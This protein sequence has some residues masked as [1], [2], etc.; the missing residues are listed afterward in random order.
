MTL[1]RPRNAA[2]F[3]AK[4]LPAEREFRQSEVGILVVKSAT[5]G[6]SFLRLKLS[7]SMRGLKLEKSFS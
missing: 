3:K 2:R 7:F 5:Y 6:E 1:Y 4:F